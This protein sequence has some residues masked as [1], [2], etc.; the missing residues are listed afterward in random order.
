MPGWS[1]WRQLRCCWV[2]AP[3]HHRLRTCD[4]QAPEASLRQPRRGA[5]VDRLGQQHPQESNPTWKDAAGVPPRVSSPLSPDA[6]RPRRGDLAR[7]ADQPGTQA[8]SDRL[9]PLI[10]TELFV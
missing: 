2:P 8:L 9:R 1:A 10:N 6:A 4:A 5:P 7:L 3:K